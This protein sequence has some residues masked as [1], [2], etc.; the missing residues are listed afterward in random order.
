MINQNIVLF[1]LLVGNPESIESEL[2]TILPAEFSLG[3]NFPNP[4]NPSTIIPVSIPEESG[5]TLKVYDILGQEIRTIFN[6]TKEAGKHYFGW[7]GTNYLNKQV[8]AGI[9]LY[10]LNTNQGHTFVGKMVL[11]K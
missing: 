3:E 9:Y 10:R 8:A 5:L 7:D 1:Q 11:V 4:F 2:N 6:G